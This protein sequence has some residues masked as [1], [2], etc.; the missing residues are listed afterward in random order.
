MGVFVEISP[1]ALNATTR[2]AFRDT[3]HD[4]WY[5][6]CK[7]SASACRARPDALSPRICS[8][9]ERL[10]SAAARSKAL[11]C[12]WAISRSRKGLRSPPSKAVLN[13][14]AKHSGAGASTTGIRVEHPGFQAAG[15]S[16]PISGEPGRDAG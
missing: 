15:R 2:K 12:D 5:K 8:I 7:V 14:V 10:I 4:D 9:T 16:C 1:A 3:G 13:S 6:R 11:A